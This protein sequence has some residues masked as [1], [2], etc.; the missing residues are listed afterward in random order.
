[1][2]G[3]SSERRPTLSEHMAAVDPPTNLRHLLMVTDAAD[4]SS[5]S[6]PGLTLGTVLGFEKLPAA[7]AAAPP[8]APGR[9]LLDI[10]REEE[11][12]PAS[13]GDEGQKINW[14]SL[15]DR[16][17]LRRMAGGAAAARPAAEGTGRVSLFSL[18]EQA[19]RHA[20]PGE[21]EEESSSSSS[22]A[23]AGE[24]GCCVCMVRHKGAAF[25]PCGH[26]FCRV[27]SRE[28]WVS[29]GNCP[30]CNGYILEILDIF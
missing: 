29:R 8:S 11:N 15:K 20:A 22:A 2:E 4:A 26:T 18:L 5:T 16:L 23:A 3:V 30:L 9:T 17:L 10:I 12:R 7:A 19:D 13:G 6:R 14:R 27:C 28:L 1:M 24:Y 21:E 25:I